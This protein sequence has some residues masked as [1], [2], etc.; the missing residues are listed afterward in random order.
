MCFFTKPLR[1]HRAATLLFVPL[2]LPTLAVHAAQ[3]GAPLRL[4]DAARLAAAQA[5]RVAASQYQVESAQ[6]DAVRAGHLPDPKLIAGVGNLTVTGP[7]A[8][9]ASAGM[10]TMREIGIMQAFPAH[11]KREAQKKVAT[12]GVGLAYAN[13][14]QLRLTT[15][16]AAAH[17]W[18]ALWATQ[19]QRSLLGK[20]RDQGRLAV[21]ISKAR[22]AGGTGNASAA[23]ATKANLETL[24]NNIDAINAEVAAARAGLERWLGKAADRPLGVPPDFSRL[25]VPVATLEA[26][27]D[28]Q[29][30]LLTWGAREN[31]ANARIA[32]AQ[33]RKHPDWSVA[34]VYGERINRS[35]M[36][37]LQFR[38]GLPIFPGN[39]QD[40]DISARF[41]DR[42]AVQ[43]QRRA[44]R[45][46]QHEAIATTF[47]SWRGWNRQIRRYRNKLLPLAADR[48]RTALAGYRGGGSV[49][50]WIDARDA[51]IQT[52]VA[53]AKALA[54]WGKAWVSLAYLLPNQTPLELSQ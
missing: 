3:P 4:T 39:R 20:L 52:Q 16:R 44:A 41:A 50:P 11:A 42:A 18:V 47:A 34:L 54:A 7:H 43:A 51:E 33:A 45:R 19:Q 9:D 27:I 12:A 46:A 13:A 14:T 22:L 37:S 36:V 10:M 1:A 29:A 24:D 21:K 8:F 35:D 23:L 28:Q 6:Q 26:T 25:Q 5:P 40:R 30:P 53:Y 2:F 49:Q 38:I 48:S 15:E 17:A 32:L 31:R